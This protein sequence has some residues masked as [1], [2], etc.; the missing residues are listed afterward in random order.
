[1]ITPAFA[2]AAGTAAGGAEIAF[3]VVPFV[4]IFVIM[5]FL[6]LRPQQKRVK[7]H[8]T[9]LKSVRRDDTVVTNGGLVGRVTK[10]A[11]DQAEIEVEIAPNVRVRVVRSMISEVR[12]KGSVKAA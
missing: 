4:L 6:I 12:A 2:Q 3:Q 5:Y 9:L 11:D 10:A 1:M 8:Q 7:D